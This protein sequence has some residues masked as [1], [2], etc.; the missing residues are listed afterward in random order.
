MRMITGEKSSHATQTLAES[1]TA[2]ATSLHVPTIL[3]AFVFSPSFFNGSECRYISNNNT[4]VHSDIN[5]LA[6][7][8][9]FDRI[10]F[11]LLSSQDLTTYTNCPNF[12]SIASSCSIA[13]VP[14]ICEG[15]KTGPGF[16]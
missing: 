4:N 5:G 9:F 6:F 8:L 14:F 3:G 1:D 11:C 13:V 15:Q 2:W 7:V 10:H 12:V 16:D